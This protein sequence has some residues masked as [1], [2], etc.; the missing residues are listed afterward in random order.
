VLEQE[1][2]TLTTTLTT[3][4]TT[5]A[6][7]TSTKDVSAA[8]VDSVGWVDTDGDTCIVY[9]LMDFCTTD[10]NEGSGWPAKGGTFDSHA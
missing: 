6:A 7:V 2:S 9:E 8:C 5:T 3:T 1:T 10:G 4:P